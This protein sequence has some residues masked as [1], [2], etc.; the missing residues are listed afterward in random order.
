MNA[1]AVA[2]RLFAAHAAA[3]R[4]E[5]VAHEGGVGTVLEAYDVQQRLVAQLAGQHGQ[6]IGYKVGLTSKRMQAMCGIDQPIG[7]VVL[8]RRVHSSGVEVSRSGFGRLGLEFEV[9]VRMGR[10]LSPREAAYGIDDVSEAVDGVCA[11]V[12]L[13][14]DR[15][16]D[17]GRLDVLSL[18]CDNSWNAGAVLSE[19]H[20]D[21]PDLASIQGIV[22]ENAVEVDRGCGADVLGHP[23]QSLAWL[24]THLSQRGHG[25]RQGDIVLTGSLVT[26]RFPGSGSRFEFVLS[27]LGSVAV[28]I[29][30]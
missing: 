21:W 12:E 27:G 16:A 4:F 9:G 19:F 17:Y 8:G 29:V 28:S 24:A 6:P 30:E 20:S 18:V 13:I 14:D 15:Q 1:D 11:A 3:E 5:P 22:W 23:F 10:D 26:T 7:G 2:A 25:L